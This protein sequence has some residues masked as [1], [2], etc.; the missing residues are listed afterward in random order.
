MKI[1]YKAN[2]NDL[3]INK[4]YVEKETEN[5]IIIGGKYFKKKYA[6]KIY[7]KSKNEAYKW[8]KYCLDLE[9]ISCINVLDKAI[10]KKE[11]FVKEYNNLEHKILK[12]EN[13]T[14]NIH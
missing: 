11:K 13:D 5:N 3:T 7:V 1:Y 2:L 6:K 10:N 4:V 14:Q 12:Q 8:L 9:I